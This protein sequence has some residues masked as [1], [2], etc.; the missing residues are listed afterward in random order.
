MSV[1]LATGAGSG[2]DADG[3]TLIGIENV[4]GS[5]SEDS[6]TGNGGN[7]HLVGRNGD[8]TL[9]GK[10]GADS[11]EG[12]AGADALH[13][14][15]G[16]DTLIGGAGPDNLDGGKGH[17]MADY[18]AS[19]AAVNVDLHAG[20]RLRRRG[21]WRCPHHIEDVIGSAGNDALTGNGSANLL[22]GNDGNDGLSGGFGKDV[23][24]G[25]GG[26]DTL[27]GGAGADDLHGGAGRDVADYSSSGAAGQRRS[28]RPV[29]V[30]A[31]MPKATRS[32][33]SRM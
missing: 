20:Y 8:D 12:N 7:N 26:N 1:N 17:D 13:G 10:A 30:Q 11:L 6:L 19:A 18:S 2:G 21:G 16:K 28:A 31:A 22:V 9:V 4:D 3:D 29:S 24:I 27:A 14:G 33:V 15:T 25:G 32:A 5:S 23:L